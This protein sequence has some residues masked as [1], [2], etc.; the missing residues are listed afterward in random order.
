MD[1]PLPIE[2]H[3]EARAEADASFAYYLER[4][5]SVAECFYLE[6]EAALKQIQDHSERWP[7]YLYGTRRYLLKRFHL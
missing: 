2:F 3:S 1:N 7:A 5:R 4:S 6:M